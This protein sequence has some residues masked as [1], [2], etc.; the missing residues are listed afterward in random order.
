MFRQTLA[1]GLL[2]LGATVVWVVPAP[3]QRFEDPLSTPNWVADAAA[4]GVNSLLSGVTAG[5][6]QWGRGGSFQDGFTRGAMGGAVIY[7]GKRL[8]VQD[9]RGAGFWGR[10][11]AAVGAS[12]VRNAGE[13][14]GSLERVV[15]PVGPVRFY[16]STVPGEH[17]GVR[18]DAATVI[19][20]VH[21]M[22]LPE[23]EFDAES[24]WSSGAIVFRARDLLFATGPTHGDDPPEVGAAGRTRAGVIY[25]SDIAGLD[26]RHNLKHERIHVLQNDQFFLT[27]TSPAEEWALR[28]LPGGAALN[29]WV[30]PNLSPAVTGILSEVFKRYE[31]RPWELEAEYLARR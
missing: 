27:L 2:A 30:D 17:L 25:L 12:V 15:L 10:E 19:N 1:I 7:T 9:F 21:A 4:A 11:V 20:A 14:R 16:L 28:R 18:L 8:A 3:A 24:S 31:H 13:G 23:L 6:M 22:Q 29:R 26:Y 5:V